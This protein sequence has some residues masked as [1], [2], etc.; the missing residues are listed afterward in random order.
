MINPNASVTINT[1]PM[2][3]LLML[4]TSISC[5]TTGMKMMIAGIGSMKSPT[6]TNT[7]TSRNMIAIGSVPAT[8]LIHPATTIGPRRYATSHPNALA[9]AIVIR[10]RL[11]TR[12]VC[13]KSRGSSRQC[14]G[15]SKGRTISR[16]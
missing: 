11:N 9:A 8:L 12:P 3:T 2:C 14:S 10:G 13:T 6:I 7:A 4:P 16:I 15:F 1:T 5:V